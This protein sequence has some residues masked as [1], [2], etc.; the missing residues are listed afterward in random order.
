MKLNTH[1]ERE[2]VRACGET[3]LLFFCTGDRLIRLSPEPAYTSQ[4]I[5]LSQLTIPHDRNQ[6]QF[7]LQI[8][9]L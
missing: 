7:R 4:R 9:N 8:L 5:R 3:H 1:A 2:G 6:F